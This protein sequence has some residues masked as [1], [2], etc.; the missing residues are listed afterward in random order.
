MRTDASDDLLIAARAAREALDPLAD[1][2]WSTRAGDLEWDAWTTLDHITRA[3][4]SY[5]AH[6]VTR[7]T[8]RLPTAH[9]HESELTPADLLQVVEWRA[10][11]L[12]HIIATVPPDTRAWHIAGMADP[13]GFRAM[14]CDEVLGH[15]YDIARG[16]DR[17]FQPPADLCR[18]VLERLF[19]WAPTD[20]DPWQALLWANGRAALPDRPRLATWGWHCAPLAEWDGLQRTS[21]RPS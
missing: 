13:S 14:G 19:P 20:G 5:T 16:F 10:T 8:R 9:R 3:L 15:T 1:A 17:P 18:R 21:I 7:A 6:L 4:M 2:D 12:A 11:L